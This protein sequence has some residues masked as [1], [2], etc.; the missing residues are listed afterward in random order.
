MSNIVI[1]GMDRFRVDNITHWLAG[2]EP[3]NLGLFH[4]GIERGFTDVLDP[5][6]IPVYSWKGGK[7]SMAKLN[8]FDRIPLVTYYL[9]RDYN[10]QN[11]PM[12]HL[13]DEPFDYSAW[14]AGK[15]IGECSK[16]SFRELGYDANNRL[17]MELSLPK[18]DDIHVDVVNSRGEHV[19]R[20]IA[21]DVEP[22]VHQVVWDNFTAPGL[23]GFYVKG[24]GWN[25]VREIPIYT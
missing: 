12:F 13:C 4:I 25:A 10:G 11:E 8:D 24:M 15:R 17:V 3:G 22:G 1:F 16:P 14:K 9:Q 7:A 6:D 5:H 20:L 21:D 19:W 18:R 2:H 23:Y